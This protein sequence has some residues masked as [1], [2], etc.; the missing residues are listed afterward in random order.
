MDFFL[1][2]FMGI[3]SGLEMEIN[4]KPKTLKGRKSVHNGMQEIWQIFQMSL[5]VHAMATSSTSLY[6]RKNHAIYFYVQKACSG[7]G[8]QDGCTWNIASMAAA[9]GVAHVEGKAMCAAYVWIALFGV[10]A[11][12]IHRQTYP[13]AGKHVHWHTGSARA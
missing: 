1:S 5:I 7:Y 2:A 10:I 6:T 4:Q 3:C 9:C 13:H 11:R 8:K 12:H